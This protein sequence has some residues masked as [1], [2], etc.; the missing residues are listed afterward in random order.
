MWVV[1]YD[2]ADTNDL[3]AGGLEHWLR[4]HGSPFHPDSQNFIAAHWIPIPSIPG[5]R[6]L[7]TSSDFIL[8]HAPKLPLLRRHRIWTNTDPPTP[9]LREVMNEIGPE[10]AL[11]SIE[12]TY[13]MDFGSNAIARN[14]NIVSPALVGVPTFVAIPDS[15]VALRGNKQ[16]GNKNQRQREWEKIAGPACKSL[17]EANKPVEYGTVS[18]LLGRY[19]L[20][21]DAINSSSWKVDLM[22]AVVGDTWDVAASVINLPES[23]VYFPDKWKMAGCQFMPIYDLI[24]S[25]MEVWSKEGRKITNADAAVSK[26]RKA[27]EEKITRLGVPTGSGR[28]SRN[29]E[30]DEICGRLGY[31]PQSRADLYY[32]SISGDHHKVKINHHTLI[33]PE[34]TVVRNFDTSSRKEWQNW[35]SERSQER[36]GR[37]MVLHNKNKQ[38]RLASLRMREYT[39]FKLEDLPRPLQSRNIVATLH[40]SDHTGRASAPLHQNLIERT[41]LGRSEMMDLVNFRVSVGTEERPRA[42]LNKRSGRFVILAVDLPITS[43]LFESLANTNAQVEGWYKLGDLFV[44][45]NGVFLGREWTEGG[46]LKLA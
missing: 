3:L 23:V 31:P 28:R 10:N 38:K 15:A 20:P 45:E 41:Y 12:F 29:P 2:P 7:A 6:D 21:L 42:V 24:R 33:S 5:L 25:A 11:L 19:D 27:S 26:L 22:M 39:D 32:Q 13:N 4:R 18:D 1:G 40:I 43:D 17:V 35:V 34:L 30:W 36:T 14:K 9:E 8:I 16:T 37:G 46:L 44:L